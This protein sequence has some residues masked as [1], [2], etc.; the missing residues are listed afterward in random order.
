MFGLAES[1][2]GGAPEAIL[3]GVG[4]LTIILLDPLIQIGLQLLQHA[5]DFLAEGDGVEL[6]LDGAVKAFANAIGLR[7]PGLP[8]LSCRRITSRLNSAL[9]CF[10]SIIELFSSSSIL[11]GDTHP[12]HFIGVIP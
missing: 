2:Q 7:V 12:L 3:A 9:Y 8:L 11:R 6:I 10:F 1:L 5:A 4:P